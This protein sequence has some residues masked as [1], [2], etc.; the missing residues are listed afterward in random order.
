MTHRIKYVEA[1]EELRKKFMIHFNLGEDDFKINSYFT[2][3]ENLKRHLEVKEY[4]EKEIELY[5][6]AKDCGDQQAVYKK[7][8]N[9][10]KL[11]ISKEKLVPI[12]E[13]I[14]LLGEQNL[15]Q[16][17]KMLELNEF[18]RLIFNNMDHFDVK[19]LE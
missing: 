1:D 14:S 18:G 7:N 15:V 5:A 19:K 2:Y 3:E 16:I 13:K 8:N 6:Q 17:Q 10:Y 4:W 11:N 9:I 12:V